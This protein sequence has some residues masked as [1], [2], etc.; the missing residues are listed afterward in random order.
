MHVRRVRTEELRLIT[1]E[2]GSVVLATASRS[3]GS[4]DSQDELAVSPDGAYLAWTTPHDDRLHLRDAAGQERLLPRYGHRMRFSPDGTSLAALVQVG[5]GD[6]SKL[7]LWDVASGSVTTLLAGPGLQRFE[8]VQGGIVIAKRDELVYAPLAG[9]TRSLYKVAATDNLQR[10]TAASA[11]TRVTVFVEYYGDVTVRSLEI[12]HPE[13][14][15]KL[16]V[17]Q[18]SSVD[19]AESS[20]DGSRIVFTTPHGLYAIDGNGAP[21]ELSGKR[22]IHSLWFTGDGRIAYAAPAS[23][24]VIDS[25]RAHR[26]EPHDAT[27]MMRLERA[28]SRVLLASAHDARAWD[29]KT[30]V[31][32]VLA[33]A[34]DGEEV[35]GVDRYQ[36]GVVLWTGHESNMWSAP[37]PQATLHVLRVGKDATTTELEH[38]EGQEAVNAAAYDGAYVLPQPA[39]APP[40]AT[41][42][43]V[44]SLLHEP[45]DPGLTTIIAGP[46]SP[47]ALV[48]FR[49]P[50]GRLISI[51]LDAPTHPVGLPIENCWNRQ[52]W[53]SPD[54]EQLV[55]SG[56]GSFAHS[57]DALTLISARGGGAAPRSLGEG[58]DDV[59]FDGHGR[60]AFSSHR[61]VRVVDA[62]HDELFETDG[63][64]QS[65]QFAGSVL[66]F[67]IGREVFA[68]DVDKGT[69]T[70][71]ARVPE[72]QRILT[73]VPDGDGW[74]LVTFE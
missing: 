68:W 41:P 7:V 8:W 73:A 24:T 16:A 29:P 56:Y 70:V 26:I 14:V 36:G 5:R 60:I 31:Q 51:D 32:T 74:K 63:Q 38:R 69:R 19:N 21:H 42:E 37:P 12:D 9:A 46:K 48:C 3:A 72:G 55:Y 45:L 62:K 11:G 18:G 6:W 57:T 4:I 44:S 25:K 23:T 43:L 53:L 39:A 15:R 40:R 49:A 10:F 2:G 52:I 34:P 33:S 35:F 28:G 59:V 71:I 58:Y 13:Q 66:R 47:R 50:D 22:D 54:G 30:D 65:L 27:R 67:A 61:G 64:V 1:P 20:P 17:L